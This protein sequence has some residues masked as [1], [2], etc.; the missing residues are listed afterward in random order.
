M[1]T[2]TLSRPL[3]H[4]L[5][6]NIRQYCMARHFH[7]RC[8]FTGFQCFFVPFH[9]HWLGFHIH[10]WSLAFLQV[11]VLVFASFNTYNTS[12]PTVSW[13]SCQLVMVF[14]LSFKVPINYYPLLLFINHTIILFILVN[15]NTFIIIIILHI[16]CLLS[17][18]FQ[19][20]W[21]YLSIVTFHEP[22]IITRHFHQ[23]L[24]WFHY[25]IFIIHIFHVRL[26]IIIHRHYATPLLS[27]LIFIIISFIVNSILLMY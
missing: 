26:F 15:I 21:S 24:L 9:W 25:V 17:F 13:L 6:I 18:G 2:V 22:L 8:L 27:L 20:Y 10:N 14:S 16:S 12:E 4:W 7:V 23:L 1:S 11:I 5:V 19:L 3:L